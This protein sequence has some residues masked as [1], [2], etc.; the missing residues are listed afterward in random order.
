MFTKGL[1]ISAKLW[2]MLALFLLFFLVTLAL[3]YQTSRKTAAYLDSSLVEVVRQAQTLNQSLREVER[4]V[5]DAA[6]TREIELLNEADGRAGEFRAA[7]AFLARND[8][9]YR[10]EYDGALAA[11]NE[12]YHHA[13][14]AAEII[15]R[16]DTFNPALREYAAQVSRALPETRAA[17]ERILERNYR[18]FAS[19]L[20]QASAAVARLVEENAL[21]LLSLLAISAITLPLLI[22]AIT[23]PISQLAAAT[24][25]LAAGN[26]DAKAP[27]SSRDE[28]GALAVSFNEMTRTLKDKSMALE[29]TTEELRVANA[30][31]SE[32]NR[33]K[34][35]FLASMSHE[36]RT[37]L[38]AIINFSEQIIEDWEQIPDDARWS[39]EARDMLDR[40]LKSARHLLLMINEL[41]DLAKIE[42]GHMELRLQRLDLREIVA[43]AVASLTALAR[44]KNLNLRCGLPPEPMEVY[45]D[46][47]RVLQILLNLLSNAIKFTEHGEVRV[48]LERARAYPGALIKVID[49]GIGIDHKHH[50]V[51]FDR[52]RQADSADSRAY[53][54]TG[55]GLNLVKELTELHG[56]WVKVESEKGK[57]SVFTIFLPF[58]PAAGAPDRG[59][60]PAGD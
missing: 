49:T 39:A 57:G 23:T 7:I 47:R 58:D 2:A 3:T 33:L 24:R 41:L 10:R 60:P 14:A 48:E 52:F 17:V 19:F 40:S 4:L 30:E 8:P 38:N 37:P 53:A 26:L 28:I 34:S 36:L 55:I 5:N 9:V 25:A 22:R 1:S 50:S 20:N 13:R 15:I 59:T 27:V 54:G 51:I 12:Y 18:A 45:V 56:G 43:D 11:F 6:Q 46:E 21:V 42:A 31:L 44:G 35:D 16:D 32:A 29:K